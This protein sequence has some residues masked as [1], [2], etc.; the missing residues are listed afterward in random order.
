MRRILAA[1]CFSAALLTAATPAAANW[2]WAVYHD[3]AGNIVV[4]NMSQPPNPSVWK[5]LSPYTYQSQSQSQLA[6]CT[7]VTQGDLFNRLYSSQQIAAGAW[8][9]P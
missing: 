5:P 8:S 6:A 9:C 2:A 3:G 4:A 7:L 1:A